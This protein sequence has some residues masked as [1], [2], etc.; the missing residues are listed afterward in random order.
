VTHTLWRGDSLIGEVHLYEETPH[1]LHG[2]LHPAP[3]VSRLEPVMQAS[4]GLLP[5]LPVI[6]RLL[7]RNL[8]DTRM[9]DE[10]RAAE[11]IVALRPLADDTPGVPSQD[12]LTLRDEQGAPIS[13]AMLAIWEHPAPESRSV[14]PKEVTL[15]AIRDG[16]YH[17]V[18][19][20][21][22]PTGGAA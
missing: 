3:D 10:H 12:V 16:C 17:T 21:L 1:Q 18:F 20:R 14:V 7:P 19:A 5:G 4:A 9:R 22:S 11:S 6:Q 15:S 13:S 2:V 8:G